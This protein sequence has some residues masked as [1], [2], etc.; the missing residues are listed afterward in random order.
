M[1]IVVLE[2]IIIR[3]VYSYKK[4]M[5][6]WMHNYHTMPSNINY[7]EVEKKN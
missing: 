7:K 3:W 1:T 6:E 2:K 4:H 5:N